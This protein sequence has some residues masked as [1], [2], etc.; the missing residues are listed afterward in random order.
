LCVSKDR[1]TR[2]TGTERH[3]RIAIMMNVYMQMAPFEGSEA[4]NEPRMGFEPMT[5]SK[6]VFTGKRPSIPLI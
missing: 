4:K 2:K 1:R 3:V 5:F 6:L